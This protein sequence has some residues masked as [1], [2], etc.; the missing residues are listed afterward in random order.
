MALEGLRADF[1]WLVLF[2]DAV[3]RY[4]FQAIQ[5]AGLEA[6]QPNV[7]DCQEIPSIAEAYHLTEA[8]NKK[9]CLTLLGNDGDN[10]CMQMLLVVVS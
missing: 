9:V 1:M 7:D 10:V 8:D 2:F 4:L 6:L 5:K 3:L